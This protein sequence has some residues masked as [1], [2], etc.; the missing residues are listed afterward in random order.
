MNEGE[1][2]REERE[3]VEREMKK[4]YEKREWSGRRKEEMRNE[5]REG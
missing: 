4:N 3:H 1:R 5:K 2:W